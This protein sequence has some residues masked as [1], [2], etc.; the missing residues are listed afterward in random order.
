MNSGTLVFALNLNTL[1]RP[2]SLTGCPIISFHFHLRLVSRSTNITTTTSP[3]HVNVLSLL[4]LSTRELGL[5]LESVSAEVIT[6][7][8]EEVGRE[9]LGAVSV[10]PGQSGGESWGRYPEEC[11]LGD[12]VSPAGLRLVDSLVEEVV[13]EEVFQVIV[14]AVCG[15]DV[16]EED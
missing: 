7:S 8:L 2:A 15:G 16:L 11:G 3:V 12:D 4:I 10:K 1:H 6:L 9:I 13:E 14:G 5:D